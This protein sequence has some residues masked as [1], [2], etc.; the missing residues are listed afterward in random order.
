MISYELI[1]SDQSKYS[2]PFQQTY[3]NVSRIDL[4]QLQMPKT[5][6]NVREGHNVLKY[7]YTDSQEEQQNIALTS[8]E[9]V[10]STNFVRGLSYSFEFSY[11]E[12]RISIYK[13]SEAEFRIVSFN[14]LD[15]DSTLTLT[16]DT[17]DPAYT[18]QLYFAFRYPDSEVEVTKTKHVSEH[19]SQITVRQGFFTTQELVQEINYLFNQN[20]QNEGTLL[21]EVDENQKVATFKAYSSDIFYIADQEAGDLHRFLGLSGKSYSSEILE[22]TYRGIT[23]DKKMLSNPFTHISISLGDV[24]SLFPQFVVPVRSQAAD[25]NLDGLCHPVNPILLNPIKDMS[26]ADISIENYDTLNQP[27]MMVLMITHE[28][29]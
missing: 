10:L 4:L 17:E 23:A 19:L 26:E 21:V 25:I 20:T 14:S 29:F 24:P 15:I 27:H 22:N 8:W 5:L 2:H 18:T 1:T 9:D 12:W 6:L 28:V 3:K 13:D 7:T 16:L 11:D